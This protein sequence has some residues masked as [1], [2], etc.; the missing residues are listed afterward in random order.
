MRRRKLRGLEE[1]VNQRFG[2][3]ERALHL[4]HHATQQIES[5]YLAALH[6]IERGLER[7][8]DL[9]DGNYIE[10]TNGLARVSNTLKILTQDVNASIQNL[11]SE[12]LTFQAK[13]D[14]HTENRL[15][16]LT[17]EITDHIE[18]V[19]RQLRESVAGRLEVFAQE[20]AAQGVEM[21]VSQD[22]LRIL[23]TSQS[24]NSATQSTDA[25]H[26]S[27]IRVIDSTFYAALERQLRGTEDALFARFKE[28]ADIVREIPKSPEPFVDL[29]CGRG[30]FL[31]FLREQ[32]IDALG[33]DSDPSA[34]GRC[35]RSGLNV[36]QQNL[37]EYLDNAGDNS[38]CG[39][40]LFHV[41]EHFA[42]DD[43]LT[44]LRQCRRV[45]R[46]SGILIVETPNPKN[47]RVGS[48]N[49]W[50]DPTHIRPYPPELLRFMVEF[51]GFGSIDTRFLRSNEKI[52][53]NDLKQIGGKFALDA[54][55]AAVDGPFDYAVIGRVI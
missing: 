50:L 52:Y 16:S 42:V 45:I 43:A 7:R 44:I 11:H 21:R 40:S 22:E 27:R 47:L 25:E 55:I 51:V 17:K 33:V 12:V 32:G 24:A 35:V 36:Q 2:D 18:I 38:A 41:I 13:I 54:M 5:T 29:G 10:V 26:L 46:P 48:A 20:I 9:V 8:L 37:L 15:A 30:E 39:I 19:V 14:E 23:A 3:I 53:S 4:V 34:I 31:V 28:Y 6:T 49:F 1:Y